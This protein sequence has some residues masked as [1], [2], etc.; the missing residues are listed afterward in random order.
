MSPAKVN[1]APLYALAKPT[2]DGRWILYD[3]PGMVDRYLAI[4]MRFESLRHLSDDE[5]AFRLNMGV[6]TRAQ[7]KEIKRLNDLTR[8]D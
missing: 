5:A 2:F 6:R 7:I 1:D 4:R 8:A 3:I